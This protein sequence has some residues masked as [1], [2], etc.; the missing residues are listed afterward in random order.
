MRK[1]SRKV[2][3]FSKLRGEFPG[4][5]LERSL[6][7]VQ[8]GTFSDGGRIK[9]EHYI[10][11]TFSLDGQ[12]RVSVQHVE[13]GAEITMPHAVVMQITRHMASIQKAQRYDKALDV[14]QRLK[15]E[16]EAT[17]RDANAELAAGR[18]RDIGESRW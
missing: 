2:Q 8:T 3:G 14:H 17:A 13:R 1:R 9:D 12:Y 16:G 7:A 18:N 10:V 4:E 6:V 15:A 11:R 5:D